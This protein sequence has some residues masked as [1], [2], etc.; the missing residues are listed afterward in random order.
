VAALSVKPLNK[1]VRALKPTLTAGGAAVLFEAIVWWSIMT[2]GRNGAG[3]SDPIG[4]FGL[5][6]H[7]PGII[8][9]DWLHLTHPA[10]S[11]FVASTGA[12][13]FFV[14]LWIAVTIWRHRYGKR[15]A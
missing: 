8:I 15:S 2:F 9:A 12:V 14:A 3:G 13:Q 11:V 7:L 10:D 4:V 5:I 1:N 6:F